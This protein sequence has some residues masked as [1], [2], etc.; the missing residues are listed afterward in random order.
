MILYLLGIPIQIF[1]TNAMALGT[2]EVPKITQKSQPIQY[3]AIVLSSKW[4]QDLQ[5]L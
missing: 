3:Y 5:V 1:G 2:L 4:S